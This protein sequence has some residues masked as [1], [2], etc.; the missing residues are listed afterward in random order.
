MIINGRTW[1]AP[2][3]EPA[4]RVGFVDSALADGDDE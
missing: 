4:G 2:G 1:N 3:I